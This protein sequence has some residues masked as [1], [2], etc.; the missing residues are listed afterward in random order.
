MIFT[1]LDSLVNHTI[2]RL[3]FFRLL[4]GLG[5]GSKLRGE[6]NTGGSYGFG[7]SVYSANSSIRII[8]AYS[9]FKLADGSSKSRLFG[10][11]YFPQFLEQ[12]VPFT[13]RA[14]LGVNRTE[15]GKA[16]E[17][18]DPFEDANADRRAI[19]LG[20]ELRDADHIGT[21]VLIVD[22]SV[23]AEEILA[24]AEDWWWPRLIS[25][26]L[27]VD[28]VTI[29]GDT[30]IPRPR[31]RADLKPF[32]DTFDLASG[33]S[34]PVDTKRENRR[35]F[36]RL[37]GLQLGTCGF[38]VLEAQDDGSTVVD[39][40]RVASVALVRRTL[41]VVEY[42]RKWNAGTPPVV[43]T[44]I[45]SDAIDDIL[46]ASEPSAHNRWDKDSL[47]L[48]DRDG[49]RKDIVRRVLERVRDFLR[50]FRSSAAPPPPPRP[51]RLSL[52]E[53]TLASFFSGSQRGIPPNPNPA[54]APV[55]FEYHRPPAAVPLPNG[56]LRLEA[57][58][59]IRLKDEA[60]QQSTHLHL[61]LSCAVLED[62]TPGDDL[63]FA[64]SC[65]DPSWKLD[66]DET[67]AGSFMIDT[68]R[69]IRFDVTSVPYDPAWSVMF[70][71]QVEPVEVVA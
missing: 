63:D 42:Y 11:G 55:H 17:V 24:G 20:F 21:S 33:V 26:Q 5:D 4:L 14:W 28:V 61:R 9:R 57:A 8:F 25:N 12:N 62:G 41:M 44:F 54:S 15:D 10:C 39:E 30:L 37:H 70:D 1:R 38:K 36:Q 53:R 68:E 6:T 50:D 7:K 48:H 67:S 19:D 58:F 35:E 46:R 29:S 34:N 59:S 65:N 2:L 66:S 56:Q 40:Q 43:G 23:T 13:G 22:V 51:R 18:V 31:S 45:A 47:R 32:L 69:G 60:V 64:I 52:L 71:P 3:K 27:D 49:L 16:R